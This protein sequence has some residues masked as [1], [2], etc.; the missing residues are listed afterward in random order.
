[1]TYK[2]LVVDDE[3]DVREALQRKLMREGYGV[4]TAVDGEEAIAKMAS[5]NPDI[6]LLDLNLP[7]CNGF[8]VLKTVR[9]KYNDRWRPVIIVS[10]R[11]EL[12]ATKKCYELEADHYLTKPCGMEHVLEGIQT[13]ISL[14]PLRMKA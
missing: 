11:Q 9:E 2:I 6:L 8:D 1:M 13:M 12:E 14:M 3:P 4:V 5:E 10:A 7:G